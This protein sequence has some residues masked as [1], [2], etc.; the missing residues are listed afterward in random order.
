[1]WAGVSET[2]RM[3]KQTEK[4]MEDERRGSEIKF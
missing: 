1:M 4:V 2:R 3:D